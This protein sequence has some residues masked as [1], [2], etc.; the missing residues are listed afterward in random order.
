M[1]HINTFRSEK[2]N[3]SLV[4]VLQ[5]GPKPQYRSLSLT[6]SLA[7]NE[8]NLI[9]QNKT[10]AIEIMC[11]P[12]CKFLLLIG[13]LCWRQNHGHASKVAIGDAQK[14]GD[15]HRPGLSGEDWG[16]AGGSAQH[17]EGHQ[18]HPTHTA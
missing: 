8:Y 18:D 14:E 12:T 7:F 16:G 4:R 3:R 5:N 9:N 10:I 6:I 1:I 17:Q 13:H 15:D 11:K 2:D